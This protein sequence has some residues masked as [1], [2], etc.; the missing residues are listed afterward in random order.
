MSLV[1]RAWDRLSGAKARR[2]AAMHGAWAQ[3]VA[4]LGPGDLAVDLGANVGRFTEELAAT[5]AEVHAF[6]PH[7]LAFEELQARVGALPN[8]TLHNA[9]AGAEAGTVSLRTRRRPDALRATTGA[10]IMV[11][12]ES[13][14]DGDSVDVPLVAFP[15]WLAQTGRPVRLLKVDIEGAEVPLFEVLLDHPG[16]AQLDK[17]FVE[18]H[19]KAIPALAARTAALRAR[20][21]GQT[22]P[23]INWDWI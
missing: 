23:S 8:V 20:T 11:E 21:A 13:V 16:V 15:E 5:G 12:K 6:E 17:V 19:E 10:S 18:T 3:A 2:R 22:Q 14:Q 9:A 7:P 4:T 1:A